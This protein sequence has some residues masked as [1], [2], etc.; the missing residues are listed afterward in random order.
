[1]VTLDRWTHQ[2]RRVVFIF[3][4]TPS[5]LASLARLLG[6]FLLRWMCLSFC[7]LQMDFAITVLG[8]LLQ[9]PQR[10][11]PFTLSVT[12]VR[13]TQLSG[14]TWSVTDI[15][16]QRRG[17]WNTEVET[18]SCWDAAATFPSSAPGADGFLS[19]LHLVVALGPLL[20]RNQT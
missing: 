10:R 11:R 17:S 8:F 14:S 12:A 9:F 19:H 7:S 18:R 20:L 4:N 15:S 2:P 3:A 6:I 16:T 13:M 5:R 1:M